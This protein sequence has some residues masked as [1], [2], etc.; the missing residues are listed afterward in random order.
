[1]MARSGGFNVPADYFRNHAR[2]NIV[3]G[4][5]LMPATPSVAQ[6]KPVLV[7]VMIG[8]TIAFLAVGGVVA[9]AVRANANSRGDAEPAAS[10]TADP[11]ASAASSNAASS[12]TAGVAAAVPTPPAQI[13]VFVVADPSDATIAIEGAPLDKA[14]KGARTLTMGPTEKI[15]VRVERPGYKTVKYP[16]DATKVSGG[17]PVRVK[18][19]PIPGARV[20]PP[21]KP[22]ATTKPTSTPAPPPTQKTCPPGTTLMMGDCVTL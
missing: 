5:A 1:M 22:V 19:D 6:K 14:A 15:T 9:Y 10:V 3:T 11:A 20:A 18:L 17:D 13:Q 16:I 2:G 7:G 12:A 8:V 21:P 4:P